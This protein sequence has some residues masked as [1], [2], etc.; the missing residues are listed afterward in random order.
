[1]LHS[2]AS[3]NYSAGFAVTRAFRVLVC[4]QVRN[5]LCTDF[6]FVSYAVFF[7]TIIHILTHLHTV[8]GSGMIAANSV[9]LDSIGKQLE[10]LQ[11]LK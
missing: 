5:S 4:L 7:S 2:R 1:M 3:S 11:T 10:V 8:A 9:S 6:H